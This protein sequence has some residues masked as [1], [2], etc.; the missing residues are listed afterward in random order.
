MT[1]S[2]LSDRVQSAHLLIVEDQEVNALFI[3]KALRA[4]GFGS[5]KIVVNG[6]EALEHMQS[7]VPSAVIMD[8]QMPV[9]DGLE[10][11]RR[12][13]ANDTLR[14]VPILVQTVLNEQEQCLAAFAAGATDFVSKPI[15]P[16]ELCAR[17]RV[18][19]ERQALLRS[20]QDYQARITDELEGARILQETTLPQ[21]SHVNELEQQYGLQIAYFHQTSSEV[22]GDLWGANAL[23]SRQLSCW[24]ADFCGHGVTAALNAFRL[25]AYMHQHSYQSSQPGAY[26][27]EINEKLLLHALK[28]QFATMFYGIMD[29]AGNQLLYAA[30]GSPHPILLRANGNVEILNTSGMPLGISLQQYPTHSIPFQR[31]DWLLV[32]SDTLIETPNQHGSC[33]S[34]TGIADWMRNAQ[35]ET[36]YDTL[37]ALVAHLK[38]HA[39]GPLRDDL[40]LTL[41]RRIC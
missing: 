41:Y 17:V 16:D 26:L 31:G 34:E 15:M 40:T 39:A 4:H 6:A 35:K 2:A 11:C 23:Y 3:E 5:I 20:L 7:H 33:L 10:C 19:V 8:I 25:H 27:A 22:G 18:H 1:H 12:M 37:E 38:G 36:A 24:M 21:A 30:A 32:Y 29:I 9:M 28:G 14:D 13:R